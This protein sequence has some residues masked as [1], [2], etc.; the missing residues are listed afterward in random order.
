MSHIS[1]RILKDEEEVRQCLVPV[2]VGAGIFGYTCVRSFHAA[3]DIHSI[4]ISNVDVK[5]ISSSK[6]CDYRI[7]PEYTDTERLFEY[8]CSLGRKLNSQ[9]KLGILFGNADWHAQLISSHLD[10]LRKYFCVPY[11]SYD[12][13]QRITNK[14]SFYDLCE[15]LDIAYPQTQSLSCNVQAPLPDL[16]EC[17]F[18]VVVKPAISSHYDTLEFAGKEK[19]Y[20]VTSYEQLMHIVELLRNSPYNDDVLIQDF[21]PGPDDAMRSLTLFCVDGETKAISGGRVMIQDRNP[22]FI[23]NPDCILS[24]RVEEIVSAGI[25]FCKHV[26]Y[27]GY[28]NFDIKYDERDGSYRFFEVNARAGRNTYYMTL[29][30]M[31]CI[32]PVVESCVMNKDM[33][34]TEAFAP[35]VYSVLPM[36]AIYRCKRLSKDDKQLILKEFRTHRAHHPYDYK[37]DSLAHKCWTMASK[38]K[39]LT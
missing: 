27:T 35:F 4:V 7:V 28:A 10:E 25:R 3:Y 5:A 1:P 34:Y 19:V 12:I 15:K 32:R 6:F 9:G 23:G 18:P 31:E 36:A 22:L 20:E 38:L 2:I 29:G 39:K 33:G 14:A 11:C 37:P 26:G 8:L 24:E 16:S 13:M 30:G 21:I 17:S